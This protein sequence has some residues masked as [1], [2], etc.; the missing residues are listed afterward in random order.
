MLVYLNVFMHTQIHIYNLTMCEYIYQ[1]GLCIDSQPFLISLWISKLICIYVY[2]NMYRYPYMYIHIYLYLFIYVYMY[3]CMYVC[4]HIYS[5]TICEYIYQDGLCI[6]GQPFLISLYTYVYKYIH[7][8]T[9]MYIRVFKCIWIKVDVYVCMYAYKYTYNQTMC[10]YIY[11][12][13]LCIDGQPFLI[14]VMYI[15]G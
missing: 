13:G 14:F 8:N 12:D 5:Q 9:L 1:D 7:I 6:E 3:V 10:E 11:Q 15:H 4:M 2:M